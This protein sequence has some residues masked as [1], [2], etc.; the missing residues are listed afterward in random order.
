MASN[1]PEARFRQLAE[2]LPLICWAAEPDGA[3]DWY[4]RRWS[5]Y[6]GQPLEE[7]RGWGWQAAHHPDDFLEVMRRWPHSVSSGEPFEMEFRLR[8]RDGVF[9]WFLGRADPVRDGAGTI[10]RWYGSTV[11]ID[12]QR[13]TRERSKRI[14][15]SLQEVFLPSELPHVRDL[16]FDAT[17]LPASEDALVGGDWY[18]AFELPDGRMVFSVGDVAGHGLTAS[19]AV[20]H[21]RQSILTLS[22]L[23]DDPAEIL[24]RLNAL[25]DVQ[26]PGT[27]VT[28]MIAVINRERDELRYA[29]AGH[30]PLIIAYERGAQAELLPSGAPPLGI[31]A[32]FDIE[33]RSAPISED[34]VIAAYT[35]GMLEFAGDID[36]AQ[37]RLQRAVAEMVG[38]TSIARPAAMIQRSIMGSYTP[39]DDAALLIVQFSVVDPAVLRSDPSTLKR[40]WRFHSSDAYSA[41]SSRREIMSFL[42]ALATHAEEL[43]AAELIL[44]EILANTVEH[45]PGLVEVKLDWSQD[46]PV[47]AVRDT[48]PGLSKLRA[49]LPND[50]MSEDGRG[51]FLIHA[52]ADEVTVRP[53]PGY[54]TEICVV[55]PL[56]RGA[57]A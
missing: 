13:R 6:T 29:G 41:Q 2:G 7:A 20:G 19:M 46:R 8:R 45:A 39:H 47:V 10:V 17:Y 48:G 30:P 23:T 24:R 27:M 50:A 9:L 35:D 14:A 40:S 28:A 5:D 11:E 18:D 12:T 21:M 54:G 57:V 53:A 31:G 38:N 15:D 4:N 55:L 36:K 26:M 1:D 52:L 43:F 32:Q 42:R 49:V 3:I 33:V 25:L 34:A 16:R 37:S 56:S 51:I 44:G 22:M